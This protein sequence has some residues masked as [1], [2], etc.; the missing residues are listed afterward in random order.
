MLTVLQQGATLSSRSY[1]GCRL[2]SETE[3][4]ET[5]SFYGKGFGN[6]DLRKERFRGNWFDKNRTESDVWRCL[7]TFGD[8][9]RHLETIML[10]V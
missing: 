4:E 10:H 8:S 3:E 2:S 5:V 6:L 1:L 7:E 9:W